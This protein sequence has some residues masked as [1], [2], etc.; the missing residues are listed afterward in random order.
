MQFWK[1]ELFLLWSC[2]PWLGLIV[3]LSVWSE[4]SWRR[5]SLW[6]SCVTKMTSF[7]SHWSSKSLFCAQ[8]PDRMSSH[9]AGLLSKYCYLLE[10]NCKCVYVE[11][12]ADY[13]PLISLQLLCRVAAD[14]PVTKCNLYNYYSKRQSRDT[15]TT[16][17]CYV[18]CLLE[19][20][21]LFVANLQIMFSVLVCLIKMTGF[22]KGSKNVQGSRDSGGKGFQEFYV[23]VFLWRKKKRSIPKRTTYINVSKSRHVHFFTW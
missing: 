6:R 11:K 8:E 23:A 19:T 3:I 10:L 14:W 17:A 7:C 4:L 5:C 13:N 2:P 1:L 21:D 15:F 18:H 12:W 9:R 22:S 16:F 20:R